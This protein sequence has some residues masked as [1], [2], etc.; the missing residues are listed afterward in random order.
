[1]AAS[2]PSVLTWP[3]LLTCQRSQLI[4]SDNN[5]KPEMAIALTPFLA[6]LNFLPLPTILLHLL[7]VPELSELVNFELVE[8]LALSL[9]LPTTRP[10]NPVSY[11]PTKTAPTADQKELLQKIFSAFMSAPESKV[12]S[13]IQ[14]LTDRYK[15]KKD[16]VKSEK[17]LVDLALMLNEQYPG[18]VGVLCVFLLNVVQLKEGEAA[19][20]GANMPHAY[21]S[22]G[23]HQ[24]YKT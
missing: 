20:L 16:I 23:E 22:G 5:H 10:P 7:S 19:F 24:Q 18:D 1:M 13:I 12:E 14:H 21:I 2:T 11:S 9:S 8:S 4:G 3:S 15:A 17:E 6:F